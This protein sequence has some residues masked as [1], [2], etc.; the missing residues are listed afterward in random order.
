MKTQKKEYLK[1]RHAAAL[2]ERIDPDVV[3]RRCPSCDRL[4]VTI[5]H[6]IDGA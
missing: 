2:L 6:R 3:R 4:F 1:I 5:I